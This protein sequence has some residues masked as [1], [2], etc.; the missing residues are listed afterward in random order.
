MNGNS[1]AFRSAM[2]LAR[3]V[4]PSDVPVLLLGETGVG[5]GCLAEEIHAASRRNGHP[6]VR[7]NAAALPSSLA[8]SELFGRER[9]AYTGADRREV[10]RFELAHGSSLFLDEISEM[11]LDIQAKLLRV[12]EDGTFE[13][14]GSPRPVRVEVRVIAATNRDLEQEVEDG[15]FRRDLFFRL[16][17]F[18][19]HVPPLR[20]RREDI[21][22]LAGELAEQASRELGVPT[23]PFS[24]RAVEI[25]EHHSWPGNVRELRNAVVRAVLLSDGDTLSIDVQ[26]ANGH[27][28]PEPPDD[29]L[30]A[31]ERQHVVRILDRCGWRVR[32]RGGAAEALGLPPTTLES[33]MVRLGIHRRR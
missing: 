31:A 22:P 15:R 18:P 11:P 8:E 23:R 19:I 5:K 25:L 17:V 2:D 9:G 33:K 6:M 10:G 26:S 4:A 28:G 29:T 30:F 7:M 32:G 1:P 27:D 12:L 21:L 14:L 24:P 16:N 3:K 13:R 20:E